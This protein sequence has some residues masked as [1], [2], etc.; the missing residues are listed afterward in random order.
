MILNKCRNN[1]LISCLHE[2]SPKDI[3]TAYVSNE[4]LINNIN[5]F[6][7]YFETPLSDVVN[8]YPLNLCVLLRAKLLLL[9]HQ[10]CFKD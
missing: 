1:S 6:K 7:Q 5:V 2:H 3:S 8:R 9:D 4:S 10:R